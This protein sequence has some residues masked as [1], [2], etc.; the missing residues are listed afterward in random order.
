MGRQGRRHEDSDPRRPRRS[1]DLYPEYVEAGSVYELLAEAHL[2]RQ[3]KPAAISEL[4]RYASAGGRS[5]DL[6]KKLAALLEEA[7]ARR[8]PPRPWSA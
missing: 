6:L 1:R 5:P 3:N 2:A 4:E 7:G 8:T